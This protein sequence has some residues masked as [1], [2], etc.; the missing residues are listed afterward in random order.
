MTS[1]FAS[2]D[3]SKPCEESSS[4]DAYDNFVWKHILRQ[5]FPRD[6]KHEW[7]RYLKSENLCGR[8]PV[9]SFIDAS[10]NEVKNICSRSGLYL[11]NNLCMSQK[12]MTIYEVHSTNNSVCTVESVKKITQFVIVACNKVRN[13]C[14]PVHFQ[15]YS[16][17]KPTK[18]PCISHV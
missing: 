2:L 17:Q 11:Y 15:E 14:R 1:N 6:S 9:Q 13:Q 18:H 10:E 3:K 8:A 7:Q 5:I 4:K 12:R 16:H